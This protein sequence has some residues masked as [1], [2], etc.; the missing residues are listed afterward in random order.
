MCQKNRLSA[1]T[2]KDATPEGMA[3]DQ[4]IEELLNGIKILPK[5]KEIDGARGALNLWKM[6]S[7]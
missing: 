1:R 2:K 3:K 6:Y 7:Y 4:N 5:V